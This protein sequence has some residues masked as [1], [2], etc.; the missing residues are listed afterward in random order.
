MSALLMPS[1]SSG[2]GNDTTAAATTTTLQLCASCD[3]CRSRKTK[4]D[5]TRPCGNCVSRY[6]KV[7]KC[8]K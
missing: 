4:C 7:N 2:G 6:R 8:E 1:A 5:G 3:R